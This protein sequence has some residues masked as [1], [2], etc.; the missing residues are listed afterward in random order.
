ML[1][2][3]TGRDRRF[4]AGVAHVEALDPPRWVVEAEQL[5]QCLEL[6]AQVR[7]A[8]N[9]L[10]ERELRVVHRHRDPPRPLATH[11]AAY[12]DLPAG[13]IAERPFQHLDPIDRVAEQDLVRNRAF[14]AFAREVVLWE[15]RAQ[16][17]TLTGVAAVRR[18]QRARAETLPVADDEQ[19]DHRDSFTCTRRSDVNVSLRSRDVLTGLDSPEV[20]DL[21]AIARGK[22]ELQPA[23][24]RFHS[25]YQL[26]DHLLALALQEH[27]GVAYVFA[28]RRFVNQADAGSGTALDLVLQAGPGAVLEVRIFALANAKQLL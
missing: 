27:D 5:L 18:P 10:L 6:S 20:R 4:A 28:I 13:L 2:D 26:A 1:E 24:R 12:R 11:I 14:P 8:G 21:I 22:L 15:E 3:D 19:L 9:P 16:Q 25:T 17:L 7:T 23:R